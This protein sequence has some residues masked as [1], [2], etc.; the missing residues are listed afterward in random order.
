MTSFLSD[1]PVP[2]EESHVTE[3]AALKMIIASEARPQIVV[4]RDD[5]CGEWLSMIGEYL[6]LTLTCM[7]AS[8][9]ASI[10]GA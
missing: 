1:P 4:A 2:H 3:F 8:A 10:D 6:R 5:R 7:S 9:D